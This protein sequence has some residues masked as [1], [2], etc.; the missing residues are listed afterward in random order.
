M[1]TGVF[2][3]LIIFLAALNPLQLL[4]VPDDRDYSPF[5]T[6]DQNLFNM[7][8]GQ[9]LPTNAA[10]L[11]ASQSLWSTSLSIANAINIES[12]GD[13]YLY[14]DYES[15]RLNLSWQYGLNENW[16]IKLDVPLLYQSGGIFDTA[17]DQW[18][19][20]FGMPRGKRPYIENNQYRVSYSLAGDTLFEQDSGSFNPA[21][22]QLSAGRRLLKKTGSELSLWAGLKLPS[23]NEDRLSGSGTTDIAAWLALNRQLSDNWLLNANAGL[24]IPGQNSYRGMTVAGN[25]WYGHAML[26]WLFN[27]TVQLKLQLQ[28]HTSYYPDS[29][30]KI[31]G[32][33]VFVMF[34]GSININHCNR[35]DISVSEDILVDAS[36]DIS[37]LLNWRY[38][39]SGC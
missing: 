28:G 26:G 12:P 20:L 8:H 11:P 6:R 2:L 18:H 31:L 38:Y 37:L 19:R 4:A 3:Y 10:L 21:D 15:Y 1:T 9:G 25:V 23:G 27:E 5:T 13:E 33:T 29:Q 16:N 7:I 36:P 34:G 35:L 24:V 30:T 17:I 32:D 14:L 22:I 39:T